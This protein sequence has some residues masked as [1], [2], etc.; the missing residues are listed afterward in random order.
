MGGAT[1]GDFLDLEAVR[2]WGA[3]VAATLC[4]GL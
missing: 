3:S 4:N 2:A 1:E